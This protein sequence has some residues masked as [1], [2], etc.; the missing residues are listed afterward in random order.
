MEKINNDK[1]VSRMNSP[2]LF[3]EIKDICKEKTS[4]ISSVI[5]DIHGSKNITKHSKNIYEDL[6]NE[7]DGFDRSLIGK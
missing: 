2:D 1:L 7:Q 6:Y 5:D 4:N 3:K